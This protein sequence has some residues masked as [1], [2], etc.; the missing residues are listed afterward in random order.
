[1][2]YYCRTIKQDFFLPKENYDDA[3]KAL[4]ELNNHNELKSGGRYPSEKKEGKHD[5]IW[6]SWM[7][8]NY[9]ETC[10]NLLE[11]L[12]QVGFEV[13]EDETGIVG[14]YYDQKTGNEEEFLNAL[15]PF[16]KDNSKIIFLGE[17][18]SM[19]GYYYKNKTMETKEIDIDRFLD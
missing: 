2:G 18:D 6:F 17:D 9:D 16:V 13:D 4:C 19:W 5:G 11:V 10:S 1:M 3:Y 15:A 14:L 8:W 7:D 12:E